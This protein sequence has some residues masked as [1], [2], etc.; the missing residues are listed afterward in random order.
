MF[1]VVGK[2]EVTRSLPY[3]PYPGTIAKCDHDIFANVY[4]RCSVSIGL[5]PQRVVVFSKQ[6]MEHICLWAKP[7]ILNGYSGCLSS[8][9]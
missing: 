6:F 3:C 1:R 8:F 2:Q 7:D 5:P 9:G 4:P